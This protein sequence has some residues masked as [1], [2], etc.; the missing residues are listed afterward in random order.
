MKNATMLYKLGSK[1][2]IKNMGTFDTKVI[3]AEEINDYLDN[4]WFLSPSEAVSNE[5]ILPPESKEL[6][7]RAELI[8]KAEELGIEFK[9]QTRTDTLTKM[10]SEKLN[11]LDK[12]TVC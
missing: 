1:L 9:P 12:K 10:I 4:G 5:S 6:P 8:K 7:T 3:P 11:E 2:N